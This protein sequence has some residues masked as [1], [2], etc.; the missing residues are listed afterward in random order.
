MPGRVVY[1]G[2]GVPGYGNL[3]ILKH[4]GNL[5]TVYAHC[6]RNLVRVGQRVQR[7]AV[8][9]EVG[10]TGRATGPHLHFEVRV[11]GR[12]QNPLQFLP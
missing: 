7:G 12:P 9:G 10:Q 11:E 8:I 5:S 6:R 4:A 2:S 3:I 1:S